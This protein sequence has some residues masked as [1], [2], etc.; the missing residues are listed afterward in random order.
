MTTKLSRQSVTWLVVYI[1]HEKFRRKGC[2]TL[3]PRNFSCTFN[4]LSL[5]RYKDNILVTSWSCHAWLYFANNT[6]TCFV[7]AA[8][9]NDYVANL[10]HGRV[11]KIQSGKL[12]RPPYC[13]SSRYVLVTT[14]K[15]V[16]QS[17]ICIMQVPVFFKVYQWQGKR[18]NFS[19]TFFYSKILCK[20]LK[21][22]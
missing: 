14:I 16:F 4:L 19:L 5:T 8:C 10:R 20:T 2:T 15:S 6:V 11:R 7:H 22:N 17:W 3:G 18:E 13:I 1:T 12:H 21:H 9:A